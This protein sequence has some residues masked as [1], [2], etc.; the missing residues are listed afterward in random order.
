MFVTCVRFHARGFRPARRFRRPDRL[1]ACAP[2]N[3][4]T[5]RWRNTCGSSSRCL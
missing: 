2:S 5:P 1:A 3:S 4:S